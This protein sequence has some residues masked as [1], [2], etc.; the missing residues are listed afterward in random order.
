VENYSKDL[1]MNY[2]VG[3]GSTSGKA[4]GVTG[5]PHAFMIGPDGK[6]A[7]DGHPWM[8]PWLRWSISSPKRSK[9]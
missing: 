2:I 7:W 4:Y 5:I 1:M 3:Y 6:I 8:G 9:G